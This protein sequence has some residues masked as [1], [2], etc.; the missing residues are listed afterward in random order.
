VGKGYLLAGEEQL[1]YI[2]F[3]KQIHTMKKLFPFYFFLLSC[4]LVYGE[5]AAQKCRYDTDITHPATHARF[6]RVHV[7][8]DKHWA[9]LFQQDDTVYSVCLLL[10]AADTTAAKITKG[11][12]LHVEMENGKR[13]DLFVAENGKATTKE[14]SSGNVLVHQARCVVDKHTL[15]YFAESAV[16]GLKFHMAG[17]T[18]VFD[19]PDDRKK[20][21]IMRAAQ[22]MVKE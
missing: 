10:N 1:D 19:E 13:F 20:A 3:Y 12:M 21:Q 7:D 17:K 8:L 4:F 5:A 2:Y 6:R 14:V 22:C 11:N 9:I 18:Q 15:S 16:T